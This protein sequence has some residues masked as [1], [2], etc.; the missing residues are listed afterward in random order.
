MALPNE[1][2]IGLFASNMLMKTVITFIS[3]PGIYMVKEQRVDLG[4]KAA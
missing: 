2:L 1:V 3:I 4:E